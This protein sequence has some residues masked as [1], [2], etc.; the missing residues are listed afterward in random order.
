MEQIEDFELEKIS[1]AKAHEVASK[2]NVELSSLQQKHAKELEAI[3]NA[4][5]LVLEELEN[6]H[7]AYIKA[8]RKSVLRKRCKGN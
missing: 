6:Q 7:A 3:K 5:E 4:Q 8:L 2:L 1:Q